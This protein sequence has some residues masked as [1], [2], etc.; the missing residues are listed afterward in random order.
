MVR[1]SASQSADLE[2]IPQ[3]ES[4]QKTLKNGIQN[5]PAWCS[6]HRNSVESK[7]TSLLVVS[8]GKT[9]NGMPPSSCSRQV[10]RPSSLLK[11]MQTEHKLIRMNEAIDILRIVFDITCGDKF[12]FNYM[13][14]IVK[15]SKMDDSYVAPGFTNVNQNGLHS[16]QCLH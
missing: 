2:F 1:A 16:A 11:N 12:C 4:C 10:V 5:F 13:F 9:L 8:L 6:A 14:S 3:M 7:L 15:N